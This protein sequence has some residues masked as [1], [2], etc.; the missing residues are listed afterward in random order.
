MVV[1][2]FTRTT[3]K[4]DRSFS[5]IFMRLLGGVCNLTSLLRWGYLCGKYK[6]PKPLL[7]RAMA[8]GKWSPWNFK[9]RVHCFSQEAWGQFALHR[10]WCSCVCASAGVCPAWAQALQWGLALCLLL[11]LHLGLPCACARSW[12][13]MWCERRCWWLSMSACVLRSVHLQMPMSCLPQNT[14]NLNIKSVYKEDLFAFV[15]I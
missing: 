10:S 1:L 11:C 4:M 8:A 14:W 13:W 12:V 7:S 9:Q 3:A 15:F 5:I 6:F 2:A